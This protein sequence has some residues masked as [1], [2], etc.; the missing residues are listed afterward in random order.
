MRVLGIP[1]AVKGLYASCPRASVRR[2]L[3]VFWIVGIVVTLAGVI[4][5]EGVPL[6]RAYN[7]GVWFYVQSKYVAWV[8][9]AEALISRRW[10]AQRGYKV[11]MLILMVTLSVPSTVQHFGKVGSLGLD[12]AGAAE[13]GV[14]RFLRTHAAPGDVVLSGE[15]ME[16][17][18]VLMTQC[19]VPFYSEAVGPYLL[20]A[21]ELQRRSEDYSAFWSA[22]NAGV[23]RADVLARYGVR[24]VVA[25]D[26]GAARAW[27]AGSSA[28]LETSGPGRLLLEPR[29]ASGT[30][31]VYQ[32]RG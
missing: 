28:G 3:S 13:L 5:P 17:L 14:T 25:V 30:F 22:W 20:P 18:V 27:M 9:A 32:V 29:F 15:K 31:T 8:F 19:R 11:L 12:V 6:G 1:L 2:F 21:A 24:Y 4:V 10:E 26:G 16:T 23:L 7:N